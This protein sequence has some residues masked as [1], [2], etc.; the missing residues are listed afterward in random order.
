[1]LFGSQGDELAQSPYQEKSVIHESA[2]TRSRCN[3]D[4]QYSHNCI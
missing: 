3:D 1:M 2:R 4:M